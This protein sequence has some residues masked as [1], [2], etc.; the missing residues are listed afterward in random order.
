V[1]TPLRERVFCRKPRGAHCGFLP[2][3]LLVPFLKEASVSPVKVGR[4]L[5]VQER[6]LLRNRNPHEE[7]LSLISLV[8]RFVCEKM[9]ST[10]LR[11][12][13]RHTLPS[14]IRA[15][16][17][18]CA[19]KARWA[20]S[21]LDSTGLTAPE[22]G[23]ADFLF[24]EAAGSSQERAATLFCWAAVGSTNEST[25]RSVTAAIVLCASLPSGGSSCR[26]SRFG[27]IGSSCLH[28]C[29]SNR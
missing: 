24:G 14:H 27:L 8:L 22:L 10:I 1:P 28:R 21:T 23:I 13:L 25:V 5:R 12:S 4:Q 9:T 16:L 26:Y 20:A 17:P 11:V 2:C 19:G 3:N 29:C 18:V 15:T 7:F 6:E